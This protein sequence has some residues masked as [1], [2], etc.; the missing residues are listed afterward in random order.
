MG[1]VYYHSAFA[2]VSKGE[3][4]GLP[5]AIKRLRVNQGGHN[6][7]FKVPSLTPCLLVPQLSPSGYVEKL[8]DGDI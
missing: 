4:L 8:S 2:D 1:R 5:V 7:V 3:Y 6:G